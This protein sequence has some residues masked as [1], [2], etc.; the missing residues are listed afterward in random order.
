MI[1]GDSLDATKLQLTTAQFQSFTSLK[2]MPVADK[3]P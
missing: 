1:N 3:A 2:D